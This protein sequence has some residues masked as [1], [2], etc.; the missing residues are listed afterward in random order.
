LLCGALSVEA[1]DF[2][3]VRS[4]KELVNADDATRG[5]PQRLGFQ[6]AINGISGASTLRVY[7]AGVKTP[8]IA[9]RAAAARDP[10]KPFLPPHV[11]EIEVEVCAELATVE[12]PLQ[13]LL[14]IEV[15][16]IVLLGANVGD[17]IIVTAEGERCARADLGR[18]QNRLAL[19]IRS[20]EPRRDRNT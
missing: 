6:L 11:C 4:A 12:V 1:K 19:R 2:R 7:L 5:D 16:D 20:V 17:P 3:V 13:D 18:H 14:S 8:T 15:G 9:T 10:K